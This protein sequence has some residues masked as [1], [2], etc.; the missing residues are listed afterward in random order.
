MEA[1]DQRRMAA[2]LEQIA[3]T[4]RGA[5]LTGVLNGAAG[6]ARAQYNRIRDLVAKEDPAA[7]ALFAALGEEGSLDDVGFSAGQLAK[8]LREDVAEE[9]REKPGK[10]LFDAVS[11]NVGDMNLGD[12]S[13]L[14]EMIRAN[15]PAWLRG[16]QGVCCPEEAAPQEEPTV[17]PAKAVEEVKTQ[18]DLT[19]NDLES[20]LA[21]LGEQLTA[22]GL[23]MG[24]EN[25]APTE[26]QEIAQTMRKL[27]EEQARLAR[28]HAHARQQLG[29]G[30]S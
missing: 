8:W 1:K 5:S 9:P 24:R 2:L 14:G 25:L 15:L 12:L 27:G 3:E 26:M 29:A 10:K 20:R 22:L 7:D 28:E 16:E 23:R 19:L 4:A 18:A 21:E 11:I 17:D 30:T 13:N 6:A